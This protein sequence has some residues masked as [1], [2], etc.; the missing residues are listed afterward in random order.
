VPASLLS[1]SGPRTEGQPL[2]AERERGR[3]GNSRLAAAQPQAARR[4]EQAWLREAAGQE[5]AA[6]YEARDEAVRRP[7]VEVLLGAD[8]ADLPLSH[9]HEPV[10][11]GQRFLL[12]VGDHHG[13]EAEGALHLPDLDPDFLAQLGVEVGQGLVE[14]EHVRPDRERPGERHPL[15]LAAESWRGKRSAKP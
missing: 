9:H 12:V 13:G 2:G 11:D 4:L 10:G 7:L 15:L 14:E 3:A 5:G 8:L 1:R 6:A